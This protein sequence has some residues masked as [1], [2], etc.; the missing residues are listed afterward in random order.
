MLQTWKRGGGSGERTMWVRAIDG[1]GNASEPA[2]VVVRL[3]GAP[4]TTTHDSDGLPHATDVTVH[5][6][7]N[8]PHSGPG[9]TYFSVDNGMWMIGD[10]VVI[11]ALGGG[12]NDGVHWIR[13]YSVD[14]VGNVEPSWKWCTVVIDA[15]P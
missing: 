5:L 11:P 13:F 2:T 8:D 10:R 6:T 12:Q 15:V 14:A 4:P 1:L 9:W 3:D 7:L